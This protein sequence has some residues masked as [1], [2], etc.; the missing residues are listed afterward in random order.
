LE[1]KFQRQEA[2]KALSD[3]TESGTA[4]DADHDYPVICKYFHARVLSQNPGRE[5]FLLA[6]RIF[7]P[8]GD[9]RHMVTC[10]RD[11]RRE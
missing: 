9:Q 11:M 3:L 2:L 4:G 6:P 1:F 7:A 10:G 5:V 8:L